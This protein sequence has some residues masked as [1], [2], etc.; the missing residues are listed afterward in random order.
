MTPA[1]RARVCLRSLF[2][3]EINYQGSVG[4]NPPLGGSI[5]HWR[6]DLPEVFSRARVGSAESSYLHTVECKA[7]FAHE[8][9]SLSSVESNILIE[10]LLLNPSI[11]T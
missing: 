8:R 11:S 7:I 3:K 10:V 9:K 4:T 5:I 6:I 2:W 1:F